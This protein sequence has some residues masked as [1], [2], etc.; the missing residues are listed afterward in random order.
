MR[1]GYRNV[2]AKTAMATAAAVMT[3]AV[4]APASAQVP[5]EKQR[6]GTPTT[7]TTV[8]RVDTV[9]VDRIMTRVDTIFRT[10]TIQTEVVREVPLAPAGMSYF[11]GLGGGTSVPSQGLDNVL[12]N[13]FNAQAMIGW[14]SNDNPFGVRFEGLY[15]QFDGKTL[16][17]TD[18]DAASSWGV[19]ANALLDFP[20]TPERNSAFYL[21]GG[22]GVHGINSFDID[23]ED[24]DDIINNDGTDEPNIVQGSSTNF[25]VNAG[26]GLRFG[27][28]GSNLYLEGRWVNVFE[29]AA[30]RRYFPIT[31][32]I[33]F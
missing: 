25:G 27:V 24:I 15:N 10:D 2:L 26:L 5:V 9:Y 30:D 3:A 20:W 33:T 4:A 1:V 6:T 28:G 7:T 12:D 16:G 18:Y 23:D 14:R 21:T 19:M 13:G 17:G 29:D 31:L 11:W 22:V 32:G 8:V